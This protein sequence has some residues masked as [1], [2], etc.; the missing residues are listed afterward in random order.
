[1]A[2]NRI[3]QHDG[4]GA[5]VHAG[6]YLSRYIVPEIERC[7]LRLAAKECG[8][9]VGSARWVPNS[10]PQA[11][12]RGLQ[13]DSLTSYL[14]CASRFFGKRIH[15]FGI[16]GTATLH[17]AALMGFDSADSSGWPTARLAAS[18][19]FQVAANDS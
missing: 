15:V 9:G 3:D 13:S 14:L 8:A 12:G 10:T 6:R 4:Y 1:M 17:L 11:K 18:F 16:G 2:M 7:P 5:W 19:N